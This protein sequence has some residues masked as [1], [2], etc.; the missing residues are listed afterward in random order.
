MFREVSTV[1]VQC[2]PATLKQLGLFSSR[3]SLNSIGEGTLW[4][5][6]FTLLCSNSQVQTITLLLENPV[7]NRWRVGLSKR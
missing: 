4:G 7:E 2:I 1:L 5:P 3:C 6:V